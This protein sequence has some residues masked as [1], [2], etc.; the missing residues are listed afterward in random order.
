MNGNIADSRQSLLCGY[1]TMLMRCTFPENITR[2]EIQN[3]FSGVNTDSKTA[4]DSTVIPSD[5]AFLDKPKKSPQ[6]KYLLT[7]SGPDHLGFIA[8][9]AAFCVLQQFNILDLSTT[10]SAGEYILMRL[11]DLRNTDSAELLPLLISHFLV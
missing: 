11:V 1:Y 3:K 6:N 10:E 7:V 5:Q 9:V 8:N 4:I 2:Q